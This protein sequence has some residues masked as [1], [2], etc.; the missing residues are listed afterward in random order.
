[1]IQFKNVHHAFGATK[2]L[3]GLNLEIKKGETMTILGGSGSGKS[4]TLKLFLG[5]LHPDRGSICFQESDVTKMKEQELV[6]MRKKIG[7]LFQGGALFDSLTVKENIAYPL[8]E[9][10]HYNEE[11]LSKIVAERLKMVGLDGIEEMIPADLSGGMKKRVGLARAIAANP[12]VVLYDEPTT[13]L[14]PTNTQRINRLIV[15]LQ[16]KMHITS[17]VVTHDMQSAF[18]VSN[19]M[20]LLKEGKIVAIG[21]VDEIKHSKDKVVQDFIGGGVL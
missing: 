5:V 19:R 7:M 18:E 3:Q 21:T 9:H 15:Q 13:G 20:A 6:A 14:D 16:E 8:R 2:V 11:E 17:I 1:M 10:F 4:V 12:S